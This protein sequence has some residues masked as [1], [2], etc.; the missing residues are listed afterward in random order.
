MIY[1]IDI[2]R[3]LTN[4][5]ELETFPRNKALPLNM[6]FL[7]G[8]RRRDEGGFIGI[9]Y[10]NYQNYSRCGFISRRPLKENNIIYLEGEKIGFVTSTTKSY[11]LNKFIS[12]GYLNK[13]IPLNKTEYPFYT[14]IKGKKVEIEKCE[15]PFI[16]TKYYRRTKK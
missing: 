4:Y 16:E 1:L 15:L 13:D 7:I 3:V 8:K 5:N 11:N 14:L 2:K 9:G 6:N 12:I 10:T